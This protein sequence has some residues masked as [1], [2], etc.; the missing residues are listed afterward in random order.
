M[1]W[2]IRIFFVLE[3]SNPIFYYNLLSIFVYYQQTFA[4]SEQRMDWSVYNLR[5]LDPIQWAC[6]QFYQN[7]NIYINKKQYKYT[8]NY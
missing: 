7:L 8:L 3:T 5:I 6:P 2:G 1:G 4:G